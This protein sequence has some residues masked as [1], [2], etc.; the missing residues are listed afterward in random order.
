MNTNLRMLSATITVLVLTT[1]DVSAWQEAPK[2]LPDVTQLMKS[3]DALEKTLG[4][5]NRL[6][7]LRDGLDAGMKRITQQRE[8]MIESKDIPANCANS[9]RNVIADYER[10]SEAAI[11][12]IE[13][14]EAEVMKHFPLFA[15]RQR[16]LLEAIEDIEVKSRRQQLLALQQDIVA[17]NETKQTL[18]GE[19]AKLKTS[20]SNE[21]DILARINKNQ[22]EAIRDWLL[23]KYSSQVGPPTVSVVGNQMKV[24]LNTLFGTLTADYER[25]MKPGEERSATVTFTPA[26][27]AKDLLFPQLDLSPDRYAPEIPTGLEFAPDTVS[28]A[29]PDQNFKLKQRIPIHP[30]KPIQWIWKAKALEK[31]EGADF[32]IS[33]NASDRQA[34]KEL[35]VAHLPIKIARKPDPPS[36]PFLVKWAPYIAPIFVVI[37]IWIAGRLWERRFPKP[38]KSRLILPGDV[39]K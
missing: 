23:K 1:N 38:S 2:P 19:I 4:E 6:Q 26:V 37:L 17:N 33:M 12:G 20:Q 8:Q 10:I 36:K 29:Q 3:L 18:I 11:A 25:E 16:E 32:K 5:R 13:E 30:E 34:N 28:S 22:T 31:F 15:K 21:Q 9:V 35:T 14:Y 7:R 24:S 39:T 27:F